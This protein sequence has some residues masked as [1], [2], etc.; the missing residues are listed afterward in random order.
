MP[1]VRKKHSGGRNPQ[2]YSDMLSHLRFVTF[3]LVFASGIVYVSI[4]QNEDGL[5]H[6]RI[7]AQLNKVMEV[8]NEINKV[9]Q[10][11]KA[12]QKERPQSRT[13]RYRPVRRHEYLLQ[14]FGLCSDLK[15]QDYFMVGAEADTVLAFPSAVYDLPSI[16]THG[17]QGRLVDLHTVLVAIDQYKFLGN[18]DDASFSQL[19]IG[20]A[21]FS[22]LPQ[23]FSVISDS[24]ALHVWDIEEKEY[25]RIPPDDQD[26]YLSNMY[27]I[28]REKSLRPCYV[29]QVFTRSEA[30]IELRAKRVEENLLRSIFRKDASQG[31]QHYVVCEMRTSSNSKKGYRSAIYFAG[32]AIEKRRLAMEGCYGG[33]RFGAAGLKSDFPDLYEYGVERRQEK[34]GDMRQ[35]LKYLELTDRSELA[36]FNLEFPL[37]QLRLWGSL[38][39]C[40]VQ[41]Y[42]CLHL[43]AFL[44]VAPPI[45][46]VLRFPWIGVYRGLL[47]NLVLWITVAFFP[48][49][50]I[51]KSLFAIYGDIDILTT[52]VLVCIFIASTIWVHVC[53]A[54]LIRWQ[55]FSK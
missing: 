36:V 12:L 26:V 49:G 42:F 43:S 2:V 32:V 40:T 14:T 30:R 25:H 47:S 48:G 15:P 5:N 52:S 11:F 24:S 35:N 53:L 33:H 17:R 51:A 55:Y 50:T 13:T 6:R 29:G 27:D 3:S 54:G 41:V 9:F 23:R 7:L 10:K 8:P 19:E 37:A 34:L 21:A 22:A 31:H 20:Y 39:L 44:K 28:V 46:E 4:F 38:I 1:L 16:T 45:R 18:L